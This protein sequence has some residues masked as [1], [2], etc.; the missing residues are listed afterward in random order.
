MRLCVDIRIGCVLLD[1][2]TTWTYVLAHEHGEGV[3]SLCCII[4]GNLLRVVLGSFHQD[5]CIAAP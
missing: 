5:L 2:L 3:V 4:D 1:E